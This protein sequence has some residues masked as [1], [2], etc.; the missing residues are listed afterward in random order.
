MNGSE[1]KR[2]GFECNDP[3]FNWKRGEY[4]ATLVCKAFVYNP[5]QN[6]IEISTVS[7]K[8]WSVD[9]PTLKDSLEHAWVVKHPDAIKGSE[10]GVITSE[11][12]AH[13]GLTT[14]EKDLFGAYAGISI[15][16]VISPQNST[17]LTFTGFDTT[18]IKQDDSDL[19]L[20]VGVIVPTVLLGEVVELPTVARIIWDFGGPIVLR[21]IVDEL[22]G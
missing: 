19:I 9:N 17:D 15:E 20:N 1:L 2:V 7:V 12:T 16:Y 14:L 4:T 8:R 5:S 3:E 21:K 11:N 10:T 6:N 18:I 22:L 13:A